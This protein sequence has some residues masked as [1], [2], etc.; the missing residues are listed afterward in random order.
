MTT[1]G[2]A[3]TG[4]VA[5]SSKCAR[6]TGF[7]HKVGALGLQGT[8]PLSQI[9][10]F[11][12]LC[13]MVGLRAKVLGRLGRKP[14]PHPRACALSCP[15]LAVYR[16]GAFGL[17]PYNACVVGRVVL[18]PLPRTRPS[19]CRCAPSRCP[20]PSSGLAC[21]TFRI[22]LSRRYLIPIG[23][24]PYRGGAMP[25]SLNTSEVMSKRHMPPSGVGATRALPRAQEGKPWPSSVGDVSFMASR[26]K[27][28]ASLS[29]AGYWTP[30]M[31]ASLFPG[32][33]LSTNSV[34]TWGL[35]KPSICQ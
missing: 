31:G 12:T 15:S 9:E 25:Y 28:H 17:R 22:I 5:V 13:G 30:M 16:A 4:E 21:P 3:G 14:S 26:S 35:L 34:S 20:K 10:T 7:S 6:P 29:S 1:P 27:L 8:A 23:I 18:C 11:V 19:L 24:R 33:R 2:G 32:G